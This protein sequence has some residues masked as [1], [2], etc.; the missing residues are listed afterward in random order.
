MAVELTKRALP[1]EAYHLMIEAGL[2]TE[3]DRVELLNGEIIDMSP[4]GPKHSALVRRLDLSLHRIFAGKLLVSVQSPIMVGDHS[5][6]EPDL[7]LLRHRDDFYETSHPVAEDILLLIEV[8]DSTLEKDRQVKLPIYAEAGIP[9]VWIV[10]LVDEL[11]EVYTQPSGKVYKQRLLALRGD[12]LVLPQSSET[13]AV[14]EVLG[15]KD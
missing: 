4:I 1:L 14:H 11:V 6:P 12:Q 10:N 8:A 13:L 9:L 15:T 3:A 7:C 5:E 2:L